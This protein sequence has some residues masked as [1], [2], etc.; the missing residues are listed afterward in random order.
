MA[1]QLR[2]EKPQD[3]AASQNEMS[4]KMAHSEMSATR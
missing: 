4:V 2:G 1:D 3:V